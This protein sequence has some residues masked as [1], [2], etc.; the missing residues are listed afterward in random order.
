MGVKGLYSYI[1][2]NCQFLEACEFRQSK[3]I[4]DGC[5]LMN[6]LYSDSNLDQK[7]AGDYFAFEMIIEE[8]FSALGHCGIDPYV[9]LDG[10]SDPSDKKLATLDQRAKDKIKNANEISLGR[11]CSTNVPPALLKNVFKQVLTKLGVNFVQCLG[12]ADAE[13]AALANEWNCPVLSNDSDFY[14]FKLHA[15]F[16]PFGCFQWNKWCG[17]DFI[18]ARIFTVS[19]F[20]A[21][22]NNMNYDLLPLFAT[23]AGNDYVNLHTMGVSLNWKR[24][25]NCSGRFSRID[26]LLRWLSKFRK[27]NMAIAEVTRHV[28]QQQQVEVIVALTNGMNEYKLSRCT[29][30]QFFLQGAVSEPVPEKLQVLPAWT[31][32]PLAKGK[33]GSIIIDA[34]VLH[35]VRLSFQVENCDLPSSNG[36][37]RSIRQVVYGL[38]LCGKQ[39]AG[40]AQNHG[41]EHYVDECDREGLKLKT[42]KVKAAVPASGEHLTLET[43]QKVHRLQVLFDTLGVTEVSDAVPLELH[44]PVYV[45][46][47]WLMHSRPRREHFMALLLGFVLSR[48]WSNPFVQKKKGAV[49]KKEAAGPDRETAHKFCE[50]KTCLRASLHL[51][52]LLCFP[53]AEPNCAQLYCGPL[54]H[55]I[56]AELRSGADPESR[57]QQKPQAQLL[58]RQLKEAVL[59]SVGDDIVQSVTSKSGHG[60]RQQH[61]ARNVDEL[62][63]QFAGRFVIEEEELIERRIKQ[64]AEEEMP[65]AFYKPRTRQKCK[66]V[67]TKK[68]TKSR[69]CDTFWD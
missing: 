50:W 61:A 30:A 38:L 26:G 19:R 7:H 69:K 63:E 58:F 40:R 24:F 65:C 36:V 43:L 12:E 18:C 51:N 16:L 6:C 67:Q 25:A 5:N 39:Q 60:A 1:S 23:L 47:F 66:A 53:L 20:C 14:I 21:S 48:Q 68:N 2:E 32:K 46:R 49:L 11:D 59:R 34:L 15:G 17:K 41:H 28:S 35:R 4:I 8:F 52:Q 31:L 56:A 27:P 22:F 9:V 57:L 13:T 62:R 3:L 55:Q 64:K 45:T 42:F 37:S 54:L 33:L 10:G 29:L 44:L